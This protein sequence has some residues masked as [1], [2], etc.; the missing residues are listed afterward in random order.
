MFNL[1]I[2]KL[3][4]DYVDF[5]YNLEC[6]LLGNCDKESI[7]KTVDNK[8]LNYYLLFKDNL[9][10]GFFECL[11]LP[12][13]VEL[14]DIVVSKSEQG[15]GYSKVMMDELILLSKNSGSNTIFLEVNSMNSKAIN[16]YNKYGFKEYSRRKNYYGDN[17]A[18]LMKL[19]L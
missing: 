14:Y 1:E 12:P 10:I 11:L 3:T 7:L 5:V 17:D 2:K 18:I 4:K 15:N 19:D 13:E 16:L 6:D 9:P 8:T